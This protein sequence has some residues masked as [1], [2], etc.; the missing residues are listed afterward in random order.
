[1]AGTAKIVVTSEANGKYAEGR[2][3]HTAKVENGTI[4]LDAEPYIGEYDGKAHDALISVTV[5]PKD[6]KLEYSLNG[7]KFTE[8]MP[9]VTMAAEEYTISIKASKEGYTTNAITKTV[10]IKKQTNTNGNLTLSATS[11]TITYPNNGT[12]TVTKNTSGGTLSVSSSDT[13]IATASISGTTVTITPKVPTTDGK[14]TTITVTSA[15][16]SNYE[17]QTATYVATVNMGKITINATAYSG[18]YDGKAHPALTAVSTNPTGTTIEYSLNGGT[19][20]TTMPQVTGASTYSISIRATKT[21]YAKAETTKTLKIKSAVYAKLY[22]DGTLIFSS[23]D[24]T[25]SSRTISENYGDISSD[26]SPKWV[27]NYGST[28]KASNVIIYD[29]IYPTNT[30]NWFKSYTGTTLDL[31]NLDTNNVTDMVG[32]FSNCSNLTSIDVS[33]FNTS[34]VTNMQSMFYSCSNLTSI[35]VSNFDTSKVTNMGYMFYN[36]FNLTSIDVSSFD[37]SNVIN[38]ANMFDSCGDLRKI[39]VG[40]KWVINSGTDTTNMFERCYAQIV[41]KQ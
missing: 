3:T 38:M 15:A 29:K 7:G 17:A 27:A 35:D 34:S 23:T 13:S 30:K 31:K 19:Y 32:M 9:K 8:V 20:S 14:K 37:T 24:Y 21:G 40:S 36:C 26:T 11:G 6:C 1:M 10:T 4:L 39:I 41:T 22:T 2:V 25:D 16:T 12:F 18:K 5:D 28:N 33:N